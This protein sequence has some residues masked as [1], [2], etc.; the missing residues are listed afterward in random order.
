MAMTHLEL[1]WI[2]RQ[3][4]ELIFGGYKPPTFC[5]KIWFALF[6]SAA[7]AIRRDNILRARAIQRSQ[8][9]LIPYHL[10]NKG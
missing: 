1:F 8:K 2:E 6:K 9:R 4:A 5:Q 7:Y 10:R 3:K